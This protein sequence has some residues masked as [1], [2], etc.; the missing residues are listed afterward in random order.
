MWAAGQRQLERAAGKIV[1][2]HVQVPLLRWQQL[3]EHKPTRRIVCTDRPI[4]AQHDHWQLAW[5]QAAHR[6]WVPPP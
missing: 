4:E 5:P 3:T 6:A 1:A 2:R